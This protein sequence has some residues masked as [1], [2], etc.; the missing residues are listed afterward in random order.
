MKNFTNELRG[1]Y[2][3]P[4]TTRIRII[5][6]PSPPTIR[7]VQRPRTPSTNLNF[8]V[9]NLTDALVILFCFFVFFGVIIYISR[10]KNPSPS[11]NGANSSTTP[12]KS[13]KK[14]KQNGFNMPPPKYSEH[15][16]V[17]MTHGSGM[18]SAPNMPNGQN[19]YYTGYVPDSKYMEHP[20]YVPN[21]P[22]MQNAPPSYSATMDGK[23]SEGR[24]VIYPDIPSKSKNMH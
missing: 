23:Q 19:T 20:E 15:S 4:Q 2:A 1:A 8:K 22:G 24:N 12:K 10:D 16:E 18:P 14:S 17:F 3:N 5:P 7:I 9:E 13:S 11:T 6:K 21:G